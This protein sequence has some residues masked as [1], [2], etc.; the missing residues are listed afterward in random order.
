MLATVRPG[1]ALAVLPQ[2]GILDGKP[3]TWVIVGLILVLLFAVSLVMMLVTRYKRCPSNK[4]LVVYG[5]VKSGSS[6]KPMH[7]GGA[8]VWP[9]IQSYDYLSLD[10][11][12]I[13][14]PLRGALS[15]ENIRVNVPS[16]F[17]VAVGTDSVTM[18]NAAVRLL[19]LSV[20]EITQQALDI[21]FGQ[22]RQV[23]AS[24]RIESINRDRD[25]FLSNIQHNLE[26][27]LEKVGLVLINVNI[28][29]ITDDSG[30]IE[31]L[32][33]KAASEA[34]QQ[35]EIDVAQ[36]VRTGA[37]GVADA[38]R[39][40]EIQVSIAVKDKE[41]GTKDAEREMAVK[42]A[43]LE[44]DRTVGEREAQLQQE[45]SIKEAERE[46][47]VRT[48]A[49]N[50][51]AVEGENE[52]QGVIAASEAS[53]Q[54][55]RAEA[56][57]IGE[58]RKREADAEV[59]AAQFKAE[60]IAAEANA[61]KIEAEQ[62]AALEA[63]ARAQKARIEVEAAAQAEKT[64][65]EAAGRAEARIIEAEADARA[66]YAKLEAQARGEYEILAKKGQGLREIVE[67]CG[68]S[69]QAFQ[70]MML[71]HI[72]HLAT[73][74]SKAISNVKFDKVTVW[75]SGDGSGQGGAAGFLKSL[76]AS[77]PPLMN[78]MRDIGGVELPEYLGKLTTGDAGGSSSGKD[79]PKSASAGASESSGGEEPS[80]K[81][82]P[83]S[84]SRASGSKGS[85]GPGSG[86]QGDGATEASAP[87]GGPP[88]TPKR[89]PRGGGGRGK[90]S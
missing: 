6:S 45:V 39:D 60:T 17:T 67:G 52:S 18:T 77:M 48:A 65:L 31:A 84:S 42:V 71:E 72:D 70:L 53:L 10:P 83:K 34:V 90:G 79:G 58:A 89:G 41:I 13:E 43:E 78:V 27:E 61:K 24:M 59:E 75:D 49:A 29:D 37:I 56:Y 66:V 69:E 8:F 12:Q 38:E 20:S 87:E 76:G 85:A 22:L 74:A 50:A 33:R 73:T 11:I 9:L 62:R 46:M 40:R 30:Y 55:K 57:A 3:E 35:A 16:F 26:P 21:I 82:A 32:G 25:T 44:R 64:K 15:A 86:G 5:K 2:D 23:I 47:R 14:V 54:V 36:Q 88:A 4:I 19:G 1:T 51:E 63:P 28:T 7:G 80:S 68:S 81:A